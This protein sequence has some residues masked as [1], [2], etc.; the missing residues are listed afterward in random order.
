MAAYSE[1]AIVVFFCFL[2]VVPQLSSGREVRSVG[3][4]MER[5]LLQSTVALE[6]FGNAKTVRNDNSSRFGKYIKLQYGSNWQV[7]GARTLHFLLEKSRLITQDEGER[8]YHVF[9]QMCAGI[10][11]SDDTS[12]KE[13]LHITDASQFAILNNGGVL[14]QSEDVD[15]VAQFQGLEVALTTLG[16]SQSTQNDVW[17]IL[18]ALL[19]MGNIRFK[20]LDDDEI[21]RVGGTHKVEL[22][23]DLLPIYEITKMLGIP[24]QT[25]VDSLRTRASVTGRGSVFFVPLDACQSSDSLQ[26]LIKH[27]YGQL[28]AWLVGKVN[29]SHEVGK[30]EK[31]EDVRNFIGILDV[32]GFEIM[33]QNSFEQLCIN[34]ANETLQQQ[35]NEQIFVLEQEAYAQQGV[36]WTVIKF[37]DNQGVIDLIAKKPTGLLIQMEEIGLLG[38]RSTDKALLQLY[39]NTHLGSNVHYSKPRFEGPEFIVTHFAGDVTYNV[40][41]FLDKNT[42]SLHDSLLDLLDS[43]TLPLLREVLG[44]YVQEP[45]L[46]PYNAAGTHFGKPGI[47]LEDTVMPPAAHKSYSQVGGKGQSSMRRLGSRMENK[48]ARSEAQGAAGKVHQIAT[49]VTVSRTFRLQLHDLMQTLRSTEPHYIK[50]I[51]PNSVKAPGGFAPH[52]VLQQLRYSGVLEVI[53]IRQEAY[54]VRVPYDE[55]YD[56]FELLL[57]EVGQNHRSKTCTTVSHEEKENQWH[58]NGSNKELS[59]KK[60][61]AT[62]FETESKQASQ[63]ILEKYLDKK[64]YQM[65]KTLAFLKEEGMEVLRY[66]MREAYTCRATKIQA[67]L[68]GALTRMRMERARAAATVIQKTWRRYFAMQTWRVLRSRVILLQRVI[69]GAYYKKRY[70]AHRAHIVRIQAFVRCC[71]AKRLAR[72]LR[73]RNEMESEAAVLIQSVVRRHFVAKDSARRR[74]AIRKLQSWFHSQSRNVQ[75]QNSV[76]LAFCSAHIGHVDSLASILQ[77]APEILHVRNRKDKF[78]MLL[79]AAAEGGSISVASLLDPRPGEVASRDADGNTPLHYAAASCQYDLVKMLSRNADTIVHVPAY[80]YDGGRVDMSEME[81]RAT[82]RISLLLVEKARLALSSGDHRRESMLVPTHNPVGGGG[83]LN[84][85]GTGPIL[86]GWLYKRRTTGTWGQRFCVAT[87]RKFMYFHSEKEFNDGARASLEFRLGSSMLIRHGAEG[88][89]IAGGSFGSS[90][91]I[92]SPELQNKRNKDGKLFFRSRSE[93]DTIKWLNP[94]R[95]LCKEHRHNRS[96]AGNEMIKFVDTDARKSLVS[97]TNNYGETPLHFTCTNFPPIDVAVPRNAAVDRLLPRR[98][99]STGSVIAEAAQMVSRVE[100]SS[101]LVENGGDVNA[102]ANNGKATALQRAAE[103]GKE[104]LVRA[105]IIK[106]GDPSMLSVDEMNDDMKNVV[107]SIAEG[108]PGSP[109]SPRLMPLLP[110][111][112]MQPRLTYLTFYLEKTTMASTDHIKKPAMCLSIYHPGG[113]RI[114]SEQGISQPI[115]CRPTYFLWSCQWYVQVPLENLSPGCL[116]ILEMRETQSYPHKTIVWGVY[117]LNKTSITSTNLCMEMYQPPVDISLKLVQPADIFLS[118]DLL[119][120]SAEAA[121]AADK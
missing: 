32:F 18:S 94:L 99:S 63:K 110:S 33:R 41:G 117:H 100:I 64:L 3:E 5:C 28:F 24:M 91:E 97:A 29:E 58:Q 14:T 66:R 20:E 115:L 38:R 109:R 103:A 40:I 8:G 105:L 114:S 17:H 116:A 72:Y 59:F 50:C 81:R 89:A 90:F 26:G 101:W 79:H 13:A 15:D 85:S 73:R 44:Y 46:D 88:D 93:E 98:K 4:L 54:A 16:I 112:Q 95:V 2:R 31:K 82:K 107:N 83:R 108:G 27:V 111:P 7:I 70:K 45:L 106:G 60:N 22:E 30:H 34:F 56:R 75:F 39:H 65:G 86:M 87:E 23:N 35:F 118:A 96:T 102:V 51:K 19:H 57:R 36:D 43:T 69:R 77:S 68:R 61:S 25:L 120:T 80:L 113:E 92:Q 67:R 37:R 121:V 1:L 78:K 6:A 74:A 71:Q 52:L 21:S 12:R 47:H 53:R 48:G 104:I 9:Y 119:L 62:S 84:N 76:R 10:I 42:D 49:T 55:F 11:Q